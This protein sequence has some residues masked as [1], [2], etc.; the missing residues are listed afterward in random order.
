MICCLTVIILLYLRSHVCSRWCL[1]VKRTVIH[2]LYATM[3]VIRA[4]LPRR[5][6][7]SLHN[8][9]RFLYCSIRIFGS[10]YNFVLKLFGFTIIVLFVHFDLMIQRF[11]RH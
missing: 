3:T 8:L 6:N 5:A 1:Q 4:N 2:N 11:P 9:V 7:K 10:R